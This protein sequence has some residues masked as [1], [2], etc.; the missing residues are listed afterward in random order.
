MMIFEKINKIQRPRRKRKSQK[1]KGSWCSSIPP[2]PKTTWLTM[3]QG[4]HVPAHFTDGPESG[5]NAI[6]PSPEPLASSLWLF[7]AMLK[8]AWALPCPEWMGKSGPHGVYS[9]LAKEWCVPGKNPIWDVLAQRKHLQPNYT[10]QKINELSFGEETLPGSLLF[11][12]QS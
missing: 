8:P 6:S 5:V 7:P 3:P 11:A 4:Q 10:P 12:P 2:Q 1:K 9:S